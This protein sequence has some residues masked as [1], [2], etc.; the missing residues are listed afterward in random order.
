MSRD[1]RPIDLIV[2]NIAMKESG[3][4]D[5][6]IMEQPYLELVDQNGNVM[7]LSDRECCEKYPYV[8][9]FC[10]G[11]NHR[12]QDNKDNPVFIERLGLLENAL[13]GIVSRTEVAFA[14]REGRR[15]DLGRV[16]EEFENVFPDIGDFIMS[17]GEYCFDYDGRASYNMFCNE[18]LRNSMAK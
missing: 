7:P 10:D 18:F 8:S 15:I 11:I 14:N 12:Y 6:Y 5:T 9:F 16:F 2:S 4:I 13:H 3:M 17:Q 1:Y